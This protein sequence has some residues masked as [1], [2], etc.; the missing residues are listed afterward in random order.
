[1]TW[2]IKIS[3]MKYYIVSVFI[4]VIFSTFIVCWS[5]PEPYKQCLSS[6][7]LISAG[8]GGIYVAPNTCTC[9]DGMVQY[10]IDYDDGSVTYFWNVNE[11]WYC[12][13]STNQRIN[14]LATFSSNAIEPP[15]LPT[16][17]CSLAPDRMFDV[18]EWYECPECPNSIE[19]FPYAS[20]NF[21]DLQTSFD[22]AGTGRAT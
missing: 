17:S 6:S 22:S 4:L 5:R 20:I 7:C 13:I 12:F 1:M 2:F 18:Y 21:L 11:T 3:D 19:P 9:P 15:P 10:R 16:I 8:E 14:D